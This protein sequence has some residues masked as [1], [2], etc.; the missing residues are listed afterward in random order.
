MDHATLLELHED[1]GVSMVGGGWEAPLSHELTL[2]EA[3]DLITELAC[4]GDTARPALV[5]L[6]VVVAIAVALAVSGALLAQRRADRDDPLDVLRGGRLTRRD[7]HNSRLVGS[8]HPGAA[9]E[10]VTAATG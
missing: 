1:T 8:P 10:G 7:P 2:A 4:A 9:R 3:D 5:A 6:V